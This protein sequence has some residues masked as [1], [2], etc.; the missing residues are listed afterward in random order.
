MGRRF[1]CDRRHPTTLRGGL[2]ANTTMIV[3]QRNRVRLMGLSTD[4][5][6]ERRLLRDGCKLRIQ[7]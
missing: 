4:E 5:G 7:S 3:R 6:R 2:G 1:H